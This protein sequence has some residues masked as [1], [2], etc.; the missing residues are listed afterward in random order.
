MIKLIHMNFYLEQLQRFDESIKSANDIAI[1]THI[2]PDGDALGSS[3]AI[4]KVIQEYYKKNVTIFISDK[5]P[6]VYEFLPC[7]DCYKRTDDPHYENK[8]FDLAI[9]T[10]VATCER[11]G[12]GFVLYKKSKVKINIDHHKSNNNYGD[13]NIVNPQASSAS[14]VVLDILNDLKIELTKEIATFIYVGILT[15][16]GGFRYDNTS[17][18]VLEKAAKLL[19]YGVSHSELCQKCFMTK[20]KKALLLTANAILNAKFL[21]SDKIAYIPITLNDMKKYNAKNEHTDRIVETLRQ[22]ETCEVALLFKENLN[23]TT[24]VSLRSKTF[25]VSNFAAKFGGGGHKFAAGLTI[26]KPL[27]IAM[28]LVLGELSKAMKND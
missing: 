9:A 27:N 2:S 4:F 8:I 11:M 12:K 26:Q 17:Q 18:K 16:T 5:I 1:F 15:D 22:I 19:N 3:L 6:K 7:L 14:E 10:D 21:L 25:D 13:I 20:E 24:K 28:D 23:Q